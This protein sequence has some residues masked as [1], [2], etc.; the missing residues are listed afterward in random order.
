MWYRLFNKPLSLLISTYEL[1][2]LLQLID[3]VSLNPHNCVTVDKKDPCNRRTKCNYIIWDY[4]NVI[5]IKTFWD[6][7][8]KWGMRPNFH[9]C[10]MIVVYFVLS[11]SNV[12]NFRSWKF[13][14][15]CG[16]LLPPL[17]SSLLWVES[18]VFFFSQALSTMVVEISVS[19]DVIIWLTPHIDLVFCVFN[20][21]KSS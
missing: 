11:V 8:F 14:L 9:N 4:Y 21:V 6:G 12:S 17:N 3:M 13:F 15:S 7:S 1:I 19:N 16:N 2:L 20:L 10:R 5:E 18:C